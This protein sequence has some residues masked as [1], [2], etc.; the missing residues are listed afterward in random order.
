MADAPMDKDLQKSMTLAFAPVHKRAL[1]VAAGLTFGTLVALVTGLQF[2]LQPE[3]APRIDLLSNYFYGYTVSPAG[4]LIGFA[5][6]F[7]VGFVAG[8]FL[9]F[10]R[11][12]ATA[13]WIF[14][15][16]AKSDLTQD[17]LDHI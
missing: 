12:L 17:F 8:W 13:V 3:G 2:L 16:R 9:A 4:V 7:L 1:G 6:A 11:N 5:W 10:V 14:F 15:V